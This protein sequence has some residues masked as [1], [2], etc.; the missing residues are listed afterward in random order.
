VEENSRTE[1]TLAPPANGPTEHHRVRVG[2]VGG[3]SAGTSDLDFLPDQANEV[4]LIRSVTRP[5]AW[6]CCG[7]CGR[8]TYW[9]GVVTRELFCFNKKLGEV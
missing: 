1:A 2:A 8:E 3:L 9:R 4:I 6:E 7:F 5:S